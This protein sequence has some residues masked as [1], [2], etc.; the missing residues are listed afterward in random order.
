ME[1]Y[2]NNKQ[3]FLTSIAFDVAMVAQSCCHLQIEW[4]PIQT[5]LGLVPG[6]CAGRESGR[7]CGRGHDRDRGCDCDCGHWVLRL[8]EAI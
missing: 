1:S 5:C 2:K 4:H 3:L 8:F 7:V 6:G